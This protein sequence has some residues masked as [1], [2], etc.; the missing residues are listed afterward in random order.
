MGYPSIRMNDRHRSLR[1][2]LERRLLA[3]DAKLPTS[4]IG[5]L[6]RTAVAGLRGARLALRGKNAG[7]SPRDLESLTALAASVGQLKGT[8]MKVGQLM[9]YLE[10]Q[11]PPELKATLAVLQTHSPP[12]PFDRVIA[13]VTAEL[14]KQAPP[15]LANMGASPVAA[16]SIGQVHR[17]RLPTGEDVAVKI[18]YPEMDRAIASD[19]RQAALGTRFATLLAP[20]ANVDAIVDAARRALIEECDY[21]REARYQE[22]FARIY[23]DHGTL[24]VPRVHPL[25]CSRRV[26]T[27]TWIEGLRF[28]DFLATNPP[29]AERDRFGEALFEFYV[30]TLFRHGLYNWDPHPGN[31]I[32]QRDG[33]IA[34]LDYGS[35]REFDRVFVRKL[36]A[37]NRAAHTDT[38]DAFHRA[39]LGLGFVEE[40]QTYD[41]DT[42]RRLVRSF[43]GPMLRDETLA[44]ETGDA[45]PFGAVLESK[46]ELLKF[47]LPGEFLFIM[48]IRFGV[49]SVLAN[50]GSRANWHRLEQQFV[51]SELVAC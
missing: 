35:T 36:A 47:H 26:L 37:L 7:D 42:A 29:Q 10:L 16:A 20:G 40:G 48:R 45:K 49:M 8:A 30:G 9:S 22:R 33:R 39:L 43:Y 11:L 27:S 50:L 51:E 28:D 19:F 32:V 1:E 46:R 21:E 23:A 13:I 2:E 5:R 24:T 38:R 12:M 14:G 15:L 25:Y 18:Q 41:F 17:A 44:I 31:Y 4:S 34:M 6:G 3:L